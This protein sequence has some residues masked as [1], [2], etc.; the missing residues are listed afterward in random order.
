MPTNRHVLKKPSC[1]KHGCTKRPASHILPKRGVAR[2][3]FRRPA[4]VAL[5]RKRVR[6]TRVPRPSVNLQRDLKPSIK[7]TDFFKGQAW[8]INYLAAKKFIKMPRTCSKCGWKRPPLDKGIRSGS[9]SESRCGNRDCRHRFT[10]F[11]DNPYFF[12][13]GNSSSVT[14]QAAVLFN[15]CIGISRIH[16]HLQLGVPHATIE[17]CAVRFETH[18]QEHVMKTQD[19]IKL[20]DDVPWADVECDEVTLARKQLGS[21]RVTWSQYLGIVQRGRPESLIL[22]R[23]PDRETGCRAPGPGPL[24]KR[25]WL[26]IFD[27]YVKDRRIILHTDS[28][29]A[30]EAFTTGIQKTR[31]V[32]QAK[33]DED[34]NWIKPHF[35]KLEKLHISEN[36]TISVL[37]G[38]QY[39]RLLAHFAP[40]DPPPPWLQLRV[41]ETSPHGPVAI[42][43]HEAQ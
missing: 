12:K 5:I 35:T 4:G 40:G 6:Y 22:M 7:I 42:L 3:M 29:R 1:V 10:I 18:I 28:A 33:K 20:G 43:D 19:N 34:G 37:A 8:T 15:L 17:R 39:I 26:P 14:T 2:L 25:D 11:S 32:H 21:D 23:L 31:V 9:R 24:R 41:G 16:I 27:R 36:E 30:Y 38:T 13:Q